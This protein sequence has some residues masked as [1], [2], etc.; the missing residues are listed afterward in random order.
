MKHRSTNGSIDLNSN[1]GS[2][3]LES[4]K[5]IEREL[6][7]YFQH[8]LTEPQMTRD[9]AIRGICNNIHVIPCVNALR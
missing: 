5:E 9:K 1:I 6:R 7:M 3:G 2:L 4:R 8:L